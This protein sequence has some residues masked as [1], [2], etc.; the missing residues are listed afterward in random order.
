MNL[1]LL[2]SHGWLPNHSTDFKAMEAHWRQARSQDSTFETKILDA[3]SHVISAA[4]SG[5]GNEFAEDPA[6]TVAHL[7]MPRI[8]RTKSV[9][10]LLGTEIARRRGWEAMRK[11]FL[12]TLMIWC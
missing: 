9:E 7:P 10:L 8:E 11:V 12:C 3:H 1:G 4:E 6:Q 5:S 2:D